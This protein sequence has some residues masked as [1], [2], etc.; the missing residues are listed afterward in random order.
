MHKHIAQVL[1]FLHTVK[2]DPKGDPKD[3]SPWSAKP[4]KGRKGKGGGERIFATLPDPHKDGGSLRVPLSRR[5]RRML[6]QV[7]QHYRDDV[8]GSC[9]SVGGCFHALTKA[10]NV[11]LVSE[12]SM[13][14][15]LRRRVQI[16]RRTE[17]LL[18]RAG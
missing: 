7:P 3:D 16:I 17:I 10:S 8:F 9:Q 15:E 11:A 13:F 1:G 2:K 14:P 6:A 5:V 18:A 4:K 12:R